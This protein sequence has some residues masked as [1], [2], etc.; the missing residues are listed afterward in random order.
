MKRFLFTTEVKL[1]E[2]SQTFRVDDESLEEAIE[3]LESGGGDI[4]EHEVEVVDIGEFKFD[5]ET[6]LA[7]FGDFPEGGAA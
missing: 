5:R 3:I 6:D 1:A 7:D 4:Y 2:G